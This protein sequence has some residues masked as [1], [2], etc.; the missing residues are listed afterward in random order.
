IFAMLKKQ[1]MLE[2]CVLTL[3]GHRVCQTAFR[4]LLG[5]GKSRLRKLRNAIINDRECPL[6]RR[7]LPKSHEMI[8]P[9]EGRSK[10]AEFLTQLYQKVAE[11]MPEL[12][13]RA[14]VLK[15]GETSAPTKK[16]GRR[17]RSF[18]KRDD[19]QNL[20]AVRMLPPGTIR[21]YHEL[22]KAE[23]P[24]VSI[25]RTLFGRVWE[26]S[27]RDRMLIR[28][29]T[30]HAKCAVCI[31]LKLQMRKF[32]KDIPQK[33]LHLLLYQEHL[34]SQYQ[35]RMKYWE[36]R[37]LS[38]M[39][40]Q[41]DSTCQ[42]VLAIDTMDHSK[43]AYPRD[44]AVASKDFA[45]WVR[46]T[47]SATG[48]IVHGWCCGLYMSES[49]MAHNSS[50]TSELVANC[51]HRLSQIPQLDLKQCELIV[52]GDNSSKETKNNTLLRMLSGLVAARRLKSATMCQLR[53]GHSHEDWDQWFSTLTTHL[54][55]TDSLHVPDDFVQSIQGWM[56]AGHTR[57]FEERKFCVKV[58]QTRAW[59]LV[60]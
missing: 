23:N 45:S 10:V 55:T 21:D 2:R 25:S 39:G 52:V 60:C 11:P 4:L 42:I 34:R 29:R 49:F 17:P 5:I 30:Q 8:Q 15:M 6:D 48:C 18:V 3:G 7:Y 32:K 53:A 19:F 57:P 51:I 37:S 43:Y 13:E 28:D 38:R 41:S 40:M 50:W 44:L 22:C 26:E 58:D 12:G 59:M 31:R 56:D 47:L 24:G 27:F 20:S 54:A 16:R 46:P 36:L 33:K 9:C 35:C 1:A 14:V